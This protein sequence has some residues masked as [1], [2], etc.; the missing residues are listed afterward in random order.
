[1]LSNIKDLTEKI[2]CQVLLRK[3]ELL[4]CLI[5]VL[6]GTASYGLGI[7]SVQKEH[8]PIEIRN[9]LKASESKVL[10]A[11]STASGTTADSVIT[12]SENKGSIVAS[13][14][15]KAYYFTTCTGVSRIAEKNKVYFQTP[16]E[17]EARGYYLAANCK[18]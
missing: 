15:G 6:V 3:E 9:T 13:K 12:P 11:S 7:L 2:K 14:N 4:I 5:I 10:G 1:M 16:A 18:K 8:S 17:A